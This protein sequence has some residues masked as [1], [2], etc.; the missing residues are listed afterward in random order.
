[1]IYSLLKTL[2]LFKIII[3]KYFV[4][5]V[6]QYFSVI[7][8]N[9]ICEFFILLFPRERYLCYGRLLSTITEEIGFDS[10]K[11]IQG[12]IRCD[13][14]NWSQLSISSQGSLDWC[15]TTSL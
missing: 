14:R 6:I 5:N 15:A 7:A 11:L 3:N 9:H 12:R 2:K 4:Y 13:Y 8:D 1:M 10:G